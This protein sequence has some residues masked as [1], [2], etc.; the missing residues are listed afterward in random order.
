MATV[1][2]GNCEWDSEKAESNVANHGVSF[3]EASTVLDDPNVAIV[4]D[5]A[6]NLKAIGFSAATRLLTVVHIERGDRDRIISAWVATSAE[7]RL[8]TSG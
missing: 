3:E 6:E 8:Y 4:D 2:F 1:T 7:E 5:G